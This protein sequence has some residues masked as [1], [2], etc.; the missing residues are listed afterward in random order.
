MYRWATSA[1]AHWTCVQSVVVVSSRAADARQAGARVLRRGGRRINSCAEATAAFRLGWTPAL[2]RGARV[3]AA[4]K[5]W[6]QQQRRR[7]R[8]TGTTN[9]CFRGSA[10]AVAYAARRRLLT[11]RRKVQR[12]TV[13]IQPLYPPT[14][15][16]IPRFQTTCLTLRIHS[17]SPDKAIRNVSCTWRYKDDQVTVHFVQGNPLRT[18]FAFPNVPLLRRINYYDD[19]LLLERIPTPSK[20]VTCLGRTVDWQRQSGQRTRKPMMAG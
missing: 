13:M 2:D 3:S 19:S 15:P 7:R 4:D 14:L 8:Q 20:V 9:C 18:F 17:T 16:S 5:N 11:A 12:P 10:A 6:Q 1:A